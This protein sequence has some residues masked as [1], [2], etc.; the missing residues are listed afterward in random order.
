MVTQDSSI[1]HDV[2][3]TNF[4]AEFANLRRATKE[5]T[6][7][8]PSIEFPGLCMTPLGTF[9]SREHFTYQQLIVNVNALKPIQFGFT[10]L[11]ETANPESAISA[12]YQFNLHFDL[13]EDMFSEEAIQV[14]Q[15]AGFDF[16]KHSVSFFGT[17]NSRYLDRW[18]TLDGLW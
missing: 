16:R 17:S 5:A 8:V 6:C 1:V 9:F 12:V 10:L 15:E 13:N 18:H 11:D 7:V 3:T 4:D 14:Y 2:W